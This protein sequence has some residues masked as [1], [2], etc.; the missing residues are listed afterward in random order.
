M[1]N[2]TCP[3]DWAK[4]CVDIRSTVILGLSVR[5]ILD[6][7]NTQI[8]ILSK[9]DFSNMGGPHPIGW[10]PEQNKMSDPPSSKREFFWTGTLGFLAFGLEWKHLFFLGLMPAGLSDT[11]LH[12]QFWFSHLQTQAGTT[13]LALLGSWFL[14]LP[15][16]L[17]ACQLLLLH[18]PIPYNKSL[19][20]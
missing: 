4:G 1:V 20:I 13:S 3:S 14:P 16:D 6:E 12:Y 15:T 7:I 18:E 8:G 10:R 19:L 5:V 9:A 11:D 2:F 17:G